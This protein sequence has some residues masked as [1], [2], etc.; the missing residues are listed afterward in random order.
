MK[1]QC[2]MVIAFIFCLMSCHSPADAKHWQST[3]EPTQETVEEPEE[4]PLS[5]NWDLIEITRQ[6]T[7]MSEHCPAQAIH[8]HPITSLYQ[9]ISV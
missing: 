5:E 7:A 3:E 1:A 8:F 4:F 6:P 9:I 2:M